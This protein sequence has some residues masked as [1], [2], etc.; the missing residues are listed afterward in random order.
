[1]LSPSAAL[2]AAHPLQTAQRVRHPTLKQK[3]DSPNIAINPRRWMER[4]APTRKVTAQELSV[5]LVGVSGLTGCPFRST[6]RYV[7]YSVNLKTS[8]I[9]NRTR[10]IG[11]QGRVRRVR[12]MT[13]KSMAARP[14]A[15]SQL[16]KAACTLLFSMP[17]FAGT[18][19]RIS[20][21]P[22]QISQVEIK[23]DC[24]VR[25]IDGLLPA[26]SKAPTC[27]AQYLENLDLAQVT[28]QLNDLND[29]KYLN[30]NRPNNG[31]YAWYGEAFSSS[32]PYVAIYGPNDTNNL[33]HELKRE[34]TTVI[35]HATEIAGDAC[36]YVDYVVF[37]FSGKLRWV[38][39]WVLPRHPSVPNV[40]G[41]LLDTS[42]LVDPPLFRRAFGA[43]QQASEG[44]AGTDVLVSWNLSPTS[45][46][47]KYGVYSNLQPLFHF[48]NVNSNDWTGLASLVDVD[49]RTTG[50]LNPDSIVNTFVY[51]HRFSSSETPN[52]DDPRSA[53]LPMLDIRSG[54]EYARGADVLN[55]ISSVSASTTFSARS[56]NTEKRALSF[57]PTLGFEVGRNLFNGASSSHSSY[58]IFRWV[59]GADAGTR[60]YPYKLAWL[61]GS[62]PYSA[63]ASF[64]VRLPIERELLTENTLTGSEITALS[65]CLTTRPRIYGKIELSAPLS[66]ILTATLLYQYG[67]LPPAF[68]FFGHSFGLSLRASSPTDY[69]H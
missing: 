8:W 32:S 4:C 31:C 33:K 38:H 36:T 11:P 28:V 61:F 47:Q 17:I 19:R 10:Y 12:S 62:K 9:R 26:G 50:A 35:G 57:S 37:Y 1:M 67:D 49:T 7:L 25:A 56:W 3:K 60:I 40:S 24:G 6:V 30:P 21:E 69:E 52:Q 55:E 59:A 18:G 58:S 53:R 63:S 65:E 39:L 2:K 16:K 5:H 41:K 22:E 64:R 14:R 66:R 51:I 29:T 68:R 43:I 23:P 46:P 45:K 20:A 54:L 27:E 15:F 34:P 13:L 44:P 48:G 42:G